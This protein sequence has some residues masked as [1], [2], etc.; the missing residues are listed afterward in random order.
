M[1]FRKSALILASFSLGFGLFMAALALKTIPAK[2]LGGYA[3]LAVDAAYPDR[4]IGSLLPPDMAQEYISESTQWVF[5]DNFGGLERIALDTYH[6]RLED[7]DPRNDG[8]G[9]KL[10]SFF[11][12]GGKRL[13]FIPLPAPSL[14]ALLKSPGMDAIPVSDNWINRKRF[15]AIDHALKARLGT[16][17]FSLE[18]FGIE[19]PLLCYSLLFILAAAG[20]LILSDTPWFTLT[21]LPVLGP[22]VFAGPGGFAAGAAL[23]GLSGGAIAALRQIGPRRGQR[24]PPAGSVLYALTLWVWFWMFLHIP[25]VF[26][27]QGEG[28][29][30]Y[31][32]RD[33]FK[34]LVIFGSLCI[35]ALLPLGVWAESGRQK[36]P[37][38]QAALPRTPVNPSALPFALVSLMALYIPSMEDMQAYRAP[39]ALG[40]N[41]YFVD[42]ADYERHLAFQRSFSFVPL[43]L[44]HT[45]MPDPSGYA[46]YSL[47][48][49]G[50]IAD[51]KADSGVVPQD[52][53]REVPPFPLED[54]I[55][56]LKDFK[57]APVKPANSWMIPLL[58]LAVML[59]AFRVTRQ[60]TAAADNDKRITA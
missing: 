24:A 22:L 50:L 46:R 54:L 44:S 10:R 27:G 17:P 33:A 41:R 2:N 12:R 38:S 23:L 37:L 58:S 60:G 40:D 14:G 19:R 57:Y 52:E 13:F 45:D 16:I 5:L 47:G 11:V 18:F 30:G 34:H 21:L 31:A 59:A 20:A 25:G 42:S 56:F 55:G 4:L 48:E 1:S 49:D 9:E 53:D 15:E 35:A 51:P 3:V 26:S 7:F 6:D 28:M 29:L 8:Y 43:G 39:G 36:S 32:D